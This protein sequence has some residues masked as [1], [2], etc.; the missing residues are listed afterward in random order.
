MCQGYDH[1]RCI[2]FSYRYIVYLFYLFYLMFFKYYM[3]SGSLGDMLCSL[4]KSELC[5]I[6]ALKSDSD[7][8][9]KN[10]YQFSF[11][12]RWRIVRVNDVK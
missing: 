3:T 10:Q 5:F 1:A 11:E 4:L 9:K 2:S 8:L 7:E 12:S 6:S